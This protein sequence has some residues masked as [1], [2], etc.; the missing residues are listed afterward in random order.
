MN[1]SYAV[2]IYVYMITANL[3]TS[4]GY[5]RPLNG[6]MTTWLLKDLHSAPWRRVQGLPAAAA[7]ADAVSDDAVCG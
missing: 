6:K 5:T 7:D 2:H 4:Y 1:K 3:K